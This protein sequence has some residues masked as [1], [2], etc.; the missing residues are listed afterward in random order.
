MPYIKNEIIDKI[1]ECDLCE[2]I[3]RIYHDPSYKILSNGTAKGL[4]PFTNE[5]TPSFVVSNVK[6]IWKDFASGKGGKSVIEFVQAYKGMDFPEAVKLSCEVLNIPIEYEKETE[7]QKAKRQEKKSLGEIIAFIKENYKENLPKLSLAQKY[8]QERG[9]SDE[10]LSDF[11]IG[12][13][14]AGMYEV[15][16]ERG[17]VSEGV[18]LGVLKA[19][20]NGGYYD[21]FKGRIIFPISDKH[22]HCVGFGG[23]V[24]PSEAKEGAPKYLN[25]PESEVFHKSELLYGFHL[26]RNSMAQR[27]EV[28]LVEGYTDVMRMHQIG[29]RNCVATLGTALSAQHLDQ[30]KKLCKKLIIFRDSDKAGATAAYRD[31]GLALEAG[32]FVERV[33][34]PSESKEDPDSIGQRE[35][36]VALIEAARCDAVLHYLQGAYEEALG[37]AETKGKKVI[38]MPEDKKRLSDLAMELIGKIPDVVTREAYLEQVKARFGIK[39]AIEK[40]KEEKTYLETPRF[41]FSGFSGDIDPLEDYQFPKEVEDPSVYKNEIL[42]YGVFQ[43]ANRI[44]CSTDKGN[45]FYDISNFSIEII[46]HM[47]DE[48]FPMKLI[49]ICNVHG[50]EKIFDVL[51]EKINTLNSFKNVVTSYG[52]FSFSGSAAQHERL[53]RYLFDRMGTGR[54]IDVLGWQAEGFWVWNNKI[55]IPGLRE[56]AINSEGLFK[57]Q[58][59]SYYIPS[60]NKNFEKNMYKYGAQKKFRSIPTEVSLPQYLKQLYKVHRGH[61]ITGILFGIGSLF[62]DIVVSCTGF[63]PILFYFG[64]ASTGKDNICEA[65]QS[66]VGQPQTAIQLEGSASTIK[67]QIREFAQFSNGISQL[68]E[69]KRGNPQV[70]GI[71]KGLWDRRGYKRGSIESKVAVDEVP[72]ISSTLLTGNDSPDAEALITR[73]IWEEMKVQEFSEEAK[74][75]YNKLKDMCRRGVS[76]LSDW[77]L[78]KRAV[79]QEHFLEVYR[80]KKRLLSERETIK[81]VPVR[82]IDNL[83]VLYAVYG[84]FEREGIFP[85]WQEDMERHFDA[86]IEN[87]RRKIESDSVYQRFW[88]CFMVCMRLTQGE[89]LQVDTNLRAEG[90][91]IYFNFSTVYS[92]V[93]RQWFVQYREQAP[94]KSEMR[95]QL[96]EDSSYMGEEK[97]IRI[98]TNINSPTSAM[99]IDIGKLRIREELLAEIEVQSLRTASPFAPAAPT[100]NEN[101]IF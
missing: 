30:I 33:V 26:A 94:G 4:S 85:F 52:N 79:F 32:L 83:A 76:G 91:S 96:R 36:A 8:M 22:G 84:I 72:I 97:S 67:A 61:A 34:F 68:S 20:Q 80:E 10:I 11:E 44:Y 78:H 7:A 89:R 95:R 38:L 14:L 40:P 41:N 100:E 51:S 88:D 50:V 57:Y 21:F 39:V 17:Q 65:I 6:G 2:A 1:Y 86:L 12:F 81:G 74:A 24:M 58:H 9:F 62:Q 45:A 71:I 93:Q 73:L 99:K 98:N 37:R 15:L 54:K 66:F 13:A 70:D 42:E 27:G 64:P 56:E 63:F 18:A 23:R 87:Q 29:L 101:T 3:G 55:V 28:Y 25:S 59:D 53:L 48:Q 69:Y 77:L 35:G 46:Q 49:R 5:R 60:A 31:M 19:Y 90:G 92:I 16:K 82:M 47:Q 75:S 43:H